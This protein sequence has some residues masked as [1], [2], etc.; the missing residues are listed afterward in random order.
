MTTPDALER[1]IRDALQREAMACPVPADLAERTLTRA[2]APAGPARRLP[3]GHTSRRWLAG[4]AAA[5]LL[6]FFV[7]GNLV[8]DG[9]GPSDTT[10]RAPS[11]VGPR[12]GHP[13]ESQGRSSAPAPEPDAAAKPFSPSPSAGATAPSGPRIART[14][15]LEV[16][17]EEGRFEERWEQAEA[18]A[19]RFAGFVTD[20]SAQEVEGRLARGNLT[21]QVPADRLDAALEELRRL[22]TPKG[23]ATSATDVSGQLVDYDARLR[24]AQANEAQLL[25]L[26]RQARSVEDN[27]AIRSRLVE[28]RREIETLQGQRASLQDRVELATVSTVLYE[29]G[30]SPPSPGRQ[31]RLDQ[32]WERAVDGA[33]ATVAGVIVAAGY[34]GPLLL[35]GLAVW[36]VTGTVRRRRFL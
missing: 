3:G 6:A 19:A 31:G 32:A 26:V 18:V 22:G 17:V 16:Q 4:A 30:S 29:Q 28:V 15:N 14:A 9:L 5:A 12:S 8:T 34:V 21:L 36:A 11:L 7:V 23:F 1:D 24:A 10:A 27:L 20:S 25:D 2:L 35:L 33:V 13:Q